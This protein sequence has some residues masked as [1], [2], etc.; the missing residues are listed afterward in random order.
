MRYRAAATTAFFGDGYR[1]P[2]GRDRSMGPSTLPTPPPA[3]GLRGLP[4]AECRALRI[5]AVHLDPSSLRGG[6]APFPSFTLSIVRVVC[7]AEPDGAAQA[8]LMLLRGGVIDRGGVSGGIG[9]DRNADLN[10]GHIGIWRFA[11]DERTA[12]VGAA[13]Q[14]IVFLPGEIPAAPADR[15]RP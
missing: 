12:D 14:A 3:L 2:M 8:C 6:L 15:T 11:R 5:R 7:D 4:R 9:W 13:R 1:F 10:R